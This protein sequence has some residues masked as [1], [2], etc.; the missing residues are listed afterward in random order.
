MS[1]KGGATIFNITSSASFINCTFSGNTGGTLWSQT[2]SFPGLTNCII[3]GNNAGSIVNTSTSTTTIS[4]STI[5]GGYTGTGNQNLDPLFVNAGNG[6]F[7]LL[8]CS[9]AIDAGNNAVVTASTDLD[10]NT[11]IINGA[12]DMGVYEVAQGLIELPNVLYVK[13][14][15]S[16]NNDGSSWANAFTI[17]QDALLRI[18]YCKAAKQ[19]WVAAGTYY[20]DEGSGLTNNDRTASFNLKSGVAI[21]GGFAGTETD[22]SQRVLKNNPTILSGEIQQ[23]NDNTNNANHVVQANGV[24][25]TAILDG[26]IITDGYSTSQG[27]GMFNTNN[28]NPVTRNCVFSNNYAP[29]NGG[30]VFNSNSSPGFT[31]CLFYQNMSPNG[32]ATIYNITS[33]AS[34]INCTFSGNTGGTLWSQTNS[35]PGLTNCIIWGNNAGSIVN[36][37]T[38]T[39]T[40]SYST[41]QGGYTGTGNQNLDPLF[42][43]AGNGDFHLL[44]C[45]PAI[46]AGNNAVVTASTDLD[47][48]TRI[49]NGA[50]DMGVYEVAQGLIELPNVLYV[51]HDASGNNDGSSWANAFTI[52]QD[53]L[54]RIKYCKAAKQIWVAAG[55]YKPTVGTDR[56]ISFIMKNNV[57][58]YGGF[59][60]TETLLAQRDRAAN[61]TILSGDIGV[62][63]D[64]SDNSYHVINNNGLDNTAILDGFTI[65]GG[66]AHG[67]SLNAD[68][69]GM[70]NISSSPTIANCI[71]TQNAA[72]FTGGAIYDAPG[73]LSLANCDFTNNSAGWG[74]AIS[75]HAV[76]GQTVNL[77]LLNCTFTG[78]IGT[79]GG[80]AINHGF[81]HST[82]GGLFDC[83]NCKFTN[84]ISYDG[85]TTGV[86]GAFFSKAAGFNS[87][88]INCT[89]DGNKGLGTADIGGGAFLIYQGNT[90]ITNSTIVNSVSATVGGAISIYSAQASV[91]LKNSI[92]YHNTATTGN[93]IYNGQGGTATV[94]YSLL[95]DA[96]CPANTTC[97]AGMILNVN[98]LFADEA[99]GDFRLLPGSPAINAG[100]NTGAPAT[101]QRGIAR[102]QQTTTDMGAFE[103]QGF[104][105][106][107]S[108][109]NNQSTIVNTAFANPLAV[110]VSSPF[111]EPV[112]GV[113]V[114]F[115]AP[116]SGA[117]STIAGNPAT[118]TGGTATTGIVTA[119]ATA[120][121]YA[122]VA[123][124]T[125]VSSGVNFSLT[126]LNPV[127][128]TS[129][130]LSPFTTCAGTASAEQTFTVS[131]A[132]LSSNLDVTAPAGFEVSLTSGSGFATGVSLTPA[133]GRVSTTTIYVRLA[134][135]A[136]GTPSGNIT[137]ASTGAT[138][139]NVAVSGTVN[140]LP[141]AT[142]IG[143][144]AVC[145]NAAQPNIT[146]TGSGGTAPYTF[147][148]SL[149]DGTN[150]ATGLITSGSPSATVPV[151]TGTAGTY[152]YT[153]TSVQDGSSTACSQTITGQTAVVTVNPLPTATISGTT[154][155]CQN[156]A[157]PGITFTGS[158]GTAPYTFTYSLS[159]GTNTTTG[160]TASGSPSATVSVPTGTAGTYTYTLVSVQDAS[161]TA[162]AQT[163]TGQ[164]AV[165]TVNP[166]PN[167]GIIAAS[168]VTS[169]STG[170]TASVCRCRQRFHLLMDR[171]QRIYYRR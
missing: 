127:I 50:V 98:P 118:I 76:T 6:D 80:G 132:G 163:I 36:T 75:T 129:G 68:G 18:K 95:E 139:Q 15:A 46:D 35:F 42:V 7:H 89:F 10:G 5:Q 145:Q 2:N 164:T 153:L 24:D 99:N 93:S 38:S 60:G 48:N 102:P 154:A 101:D 56:T 92:L 13:H 1:P 16:G 34:F 78:N 144:T 135:T 120:G 151:P 138:T 58:I 21:Y 22:L 123:N 150:T 137:C 110:T 88:F 167:A 108:G 155:V 106:V 125:G 30:A 162:C 45:S 152:T 117:S 27:G 25:A 85:S 133:T 157:Q 166:L 65:T 149:F 148:Y 114:T 96:S 12:V 171:N 146:F 20:P 29:N 66:V 134:A 19:I 43:N 70:L 159:D 160:L 31:N 105:M 91:V 81:S 116:G 128:T 69:G 26:F 59:T 71:F 94:A 28:A 83:T 140:P 90:T 141:T 103:S 130:T 84:N 122:V 41:I 161:S 156:A 57:A 109:G 86:G 74:G 126:N 61:V 165:V 115:T 113:K 40:I 39:T 53:A 72:S 55:T 67:S 33:S 158:G 142:I 147:T 47:G 143:T 9:P 100:T 11:R 170:N 52:L 32:G 111:G 79:G 112:D 77:T 121:S 82:G 124:A 54:L 8:P 119:N 169:V 107:I 168:P 4:Y 73:N 37:S 87:N 23:D 62:V 136:S 131:G 104:T 14:N 49:I 97:G 44:P 17:L 3:W 51:K 63:S 64:T